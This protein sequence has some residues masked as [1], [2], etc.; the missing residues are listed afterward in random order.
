MNLLSI[1]DMTLCIPLRIDSDSRKRNIE[2]LL[3]YLKSNIDCSILILE[4]DITPSFRQCAESFC[5]QY[6]FIEDTNPIFHR[7]KYIN[8]ML[9]LVSTP[10][11]GI[12]DCD[13]ITYPEQIQRA[14]HLLES[15][16]ITL[17]YPYDGRFVY[18]DQYYSEIF[19][20]SLNVGLLDMMYYT[21]CLFQGKGAVGGAFIVNVE[22][23]LGIGGENEFFY[24][25][26]PEDAERE[27][28]A[29]IMEA[30]IAR[31]EGPL[32]HLFHIRGTGS[33]FFSQEIQLQ[34][35]GELCKIC[36][37]NKDELQQY[38]YEYLLPLSH[39]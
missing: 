5:V 9:H 13:V 3:K 2:H 21:K 25:W 12:W 14:C 36:S 27:K 39:I 16:D 7:T 28:R 23:Y 38:I 11:V 19:Y 8:R 15:K 33:R 20:R 24:G 29:E 4:A 10:L 32:F 34:N 1:K 30:G 26:G 6:H 35:M 37:L 18:V 17:V 22:R 31:V